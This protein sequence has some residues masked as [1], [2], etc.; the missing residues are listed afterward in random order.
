MKDFIFGT[1]ATLH[2]HLFGIH[3]E[4]GGLSLAFGIWLLVLL[5]GTYALAYRQKWWHIVGYCLLTG[6]AWDL[7]AYLFLAGYIR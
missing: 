2:S 4:V 1:F 3:I 6:A 7:F 5:A